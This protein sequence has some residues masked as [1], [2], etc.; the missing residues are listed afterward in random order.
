MRVR[1]LSRGSEQGD[2]KPPPFIGSTIDAVQN[3]PRL[4]Q[5]SHCNA[6][7]GGNGLQLELPKIGEGRLRESIRWLL[8]HECDGVRAE[9]MERDYRFRA[10]WC[11]RTFGDCKLETLVGRRGYELMRKV[12]QDEK[13]SET[14]MKNVSIKKRLQFLLRVLSVAANRE[15]VDRSKIPEMP[16][17]ANDGVPKNAFHTYD[18]YKRFRSA[19]PTPRHRIYTDLGFWTGMR[20]EDLESTLKEWV[21]PYRPFT[22]EKGKTIS[23]GCFW[24]RN[25]KRRDFGSYWIPMEEEFRRC[26]KEFYESFPLAASDLVTGKFSKP[27]RWMDPAAQRSGTPRITPHCW[28]RSRQTY[29]ESRGVAHSDILYAL[30]ASSIGVAKTHYLRPTPATLRRITAK[31]PE[32]D[33][34]DPLSTT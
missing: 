24:V 4:T 27:A 33:I 12:I 19:L 18:Q 1:E 17:L 13:E 16:Q 5:R 26:V 11:L 8:E 29:L 7:T 32:D 14:G 3:A 6:S 22:D 25:H 28:R 2:G 30:G 15:L 23:I 34:P 9:T 21:D 20:R 10:E 31:P